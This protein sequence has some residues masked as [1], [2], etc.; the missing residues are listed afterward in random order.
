MSCLVLPYWSGDDTEK[1]W[2]HLFLERPKMITAG[3]LGE[4]VSPQGTLGD[5]LV[6]EWVQS[7]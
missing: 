5:A 7:P 6:K 4:A 3:G 2:V 1:I